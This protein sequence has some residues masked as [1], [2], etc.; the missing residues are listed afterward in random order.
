MYRTDCGTAHPIRILSTS[1]ISFSIFSVCSYSRVS[2]SMDQKIRSV[3]VN[4]LESPVP[5]FIDPVFTKTSPKCSF[6]VTQNERFGLVFAETG[7]IISGTGIDSQPS[8]IHS[9]E[10][11]PRLHKRLQ[12][13]LGLC[14]H[15]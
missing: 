5:E 10:S 8:G 7:S 3:F 13:G 11:I 2:I 12:I 6:S 15:T 4:L 14:K 1:F 9:L